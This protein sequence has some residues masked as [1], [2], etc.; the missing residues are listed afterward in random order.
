IGGK[1]RYVYLPKPLPVHLEY[2]TAYVDEFGDLQ[3]REDL[4]GYSRKVR[5]ALGLEPPGPR[6]SAM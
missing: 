1:E 2:F 3:L 5:A 4:Y 6:A